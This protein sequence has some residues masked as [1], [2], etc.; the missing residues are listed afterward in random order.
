MHL[1]ASVAWRL[2]VVALLIT[3]AVA[4]A[5]STASGSS[6]GTASTTAGITNFVKYVQGKPGAADPKLTPVKIGWVNNQGGSIS[7]IG[8][9][10]TGAAEF[11]VKWINKHASGIGGHPLV[12]DECLIKNAEEE[13]QACAQRFLNDPSVNVISFGAVSVGATTI[14]SAVAGKKPIISGFGL[15]QA[16]LTTP[17]TFILFAAGSYGN[18]TLGTFAHDYLHAKSAAIVYPAVAGQTEN[19]AA[20][21]LALKY[22][23]IKSKAVGFNPSTSDLVGAL[24]A[25]GAQ[26]A[27]MVF[28]PVFSGANCLSIAKGIKQLGISPNKVVWYSQCQL[29]SLLKGFGGDYPK[30]YSGIAQSGDALLKT[31]TGLIFRKALAEFGLQKWNLDNWYSGVFGQILTLAQFMN[32]IG[33]DNLSPATIIAKA[34][35]FKGPLLLGG[36]IVH[37]GKY[38]AAPANCGDGNYFIKYVGHGKFVR[39]TGWLQPPP[40]LQKALHAK[41]DTP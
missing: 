17:N 1:K 4:V 28:V 6:T 23:G 32:S 41:P 33:V 26:S 24:T 37:C 25:A 21:K 12:L 27:G 29:P 36:P 13:G 16:D 20:V 2:C 15:N 39:S 31:P 14:D 9:E 7:A 35:Q 40:A 22:A 38:P 3:A 11:A 8:P 5:V 30:Y 34:K 19:A 18:Y 10:A